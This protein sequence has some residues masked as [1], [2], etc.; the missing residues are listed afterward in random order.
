MAYRCSSKP[1]LSGTNPV[2]RFLDVDNDGF[3]GP[4]DALLVINQLGDS[5]PLRAADTRTSQPTLARLADDL[6]AVDE[7]EEGEQPARDIGFLPWGRI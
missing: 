2:D 3:V 1:A 5:S 6:W 4:L 7:G